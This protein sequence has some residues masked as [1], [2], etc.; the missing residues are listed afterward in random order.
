ME[1]IS[2]YICVTYDISSRSNPIS[3]FNIWLRVYSSSLDSS[4]KITFYAFKTK[5][6]RAKWREV[7]I[8]LQ[9]LMNIIKAILVQIQIKN[10]L[11]E[12]SFH[13]FYWYLLIV[14]LFVNTFGLLNISNRH[15]T[16]MKLNDHVFIVLKLWWWNHRNHKILEW[17]A[18][19][20]GFLLNE[21]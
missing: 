2:I 4:S 21:I 6:K 16:F 7:I 12:K 8:A 18:I 19:R 3:T 13:L 1:N 20:D 10:I 17:P 15:E 5:L 11:I 9:Y 14:N